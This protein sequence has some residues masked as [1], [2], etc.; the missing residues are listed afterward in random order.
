MSWGSMYVLS[1]VLSAIW[2]LP[3][4]PFPCLGDMDRVS[5]QNLLHCFWKKPG[6]RGWARAAGGRKREG[7][8]AGGGH[9]LVLASSR[10]FQITRCMQALA[11]SLELCPS[12]V[13]WAEGQG[14]PA[15]G[16]HLASAKPQPCPPLAPSFTVILD[17][18]SEVVSHEIPQGALV[19]EAQAVWEEHRCVHHSAVDDLWEQ[20][21]SPGRVQDP[22]RPSTAARAWEDSRAAGLITDPQPHSP[23]EDAAWETRVPSRPAGRSL[24]CVQ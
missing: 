16:P 3:C 21:A 24:G 11:S 4:S 17:D 19:G 23:S 18:L 8:W 2:L 20:P 7:R 10:I 22:R 12:T 1:W 6:A 14:E 13:E 9:R 5:S 15:L